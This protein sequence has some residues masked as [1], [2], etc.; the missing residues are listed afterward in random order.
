MPEL[1]EVETIRLGLHRYL[2]GKIIQQVEVRIPKLFSGDLKN[3]EHNQIL[4]VRRRAKV[5]IIDLAG[6]HSLLV[7]LKMT[8]QLVYKSENE[9]EKVVGGH[10][11]EAYNQP[12]PHKH[13]H[14]IFYFTDSSALYFNDLRKFGWIHVVPTDEAY[15]YG[16]LK[17]VGPEPLDPRVFTKDVLQNRLQKY[18]NRL[19]YQALLDQS[20]IAG[21]GN[22]YANEALYESGIHPERR[23]KDIKEDEWP[24]LFKAIVNVLQQSIRYGGTSDST[25][26]N[27]EG[28]RGDYLKHAHVYRK[29]TAYP[30]GHEVTHKKIGGR[31]VHYCE[32]DQK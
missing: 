11:Q 24:K 5:L 17:T 23:I 19:I 9:K 15:T 18:P 2:P 20:L 25:F 3:V 8:G 13:T 6:G 14:I 31:M 29:K 28:K 12:L 22:I 27:A 4:S 16:M 30:C 21:I 7:H 1:P 10:P 26:V 32:V